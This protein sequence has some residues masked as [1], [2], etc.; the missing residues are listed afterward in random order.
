[1]SVKTHQ[2][3]GCYHQSTQEKLL[4]TWTMSVRESSNKRVLCTPDIWA[5]EGGKWK[6]LTWSCCPHDEF[7]KLKDPSN[8]L[9]TQDMDNFYNVENA[10]SALEQSERFSPT[11]ELVFTIQGIVGKKMHPPIL[12]N[13]RGSKAGPFMRQGVTLVGLGMA[14]FNNAFD[15]IDK[16]YGIF[17]RALPEGSLGPWDCIAC[18]KDPSLHVSNRLLTPKKDAL[19]MKA[20][21]PENGVN[22]H[23]VLRAIINKGE[24][25]YCDNNEVKYFKCK[26]DENGKKKGV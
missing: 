21:E 7:S 12:E 9:T 13:K 8:Q 17:G 11:E 5:V 2:N 4:K 24:Y 20:I 19:N 14:T 10:K 23:G 3:S 22:L 26:T 25:L 1:M 18:S 6:M 15:M 16:I